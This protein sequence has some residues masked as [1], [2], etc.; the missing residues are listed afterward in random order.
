MKGVLP[1]PRIQHDVIYATRDYMKEVQGH[2][3]NFININ[4]LT[5]FI[6]R[7][8]AVNGDYPNFRGLDWFTT[9]VRAGTAIR[10]M[11]W[12]R[13]SHVAYEVPEGIGSRMEEC[14]HGRK[15]LCDVQ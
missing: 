5:D 1:W 4:N 6:C 2:K 15:E 10:K 14:K 13:R 7:K 8:T 3:L 9:K 12:V 11:G